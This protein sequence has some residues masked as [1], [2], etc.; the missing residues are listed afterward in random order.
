MK[1]TKKQ[2]DEFFKT[3]I[4]PAIKVLE[5][6]GFADRQLRTASYKHYID[7]LYRDGEITEKQANSFIIPK[8][9]LK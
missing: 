6:G 5:Y 9:F 1:R 8:I 7:S 4:L 3:E 2:V